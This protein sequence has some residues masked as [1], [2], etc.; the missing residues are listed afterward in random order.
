M[1]H[2]YKTVLTKIPTDL[3]GLVAAFL[4]FAFSPC[5]GQD[6]NNINSQSITHY[7]NGE[8][9][10][11]VKLADEALK[12][13]AKKYGEVSDQYINSLSNKAYAQSG[14]GNYNQATD[15]FRKVTILCFKQYSL[16][17]VVQVES[18][19]ELAKTF[20]TLSVYDSGALYINQARYVFNTIYEK[21]RNH[22]DTAIYV[23]ADA[24]FK[25]NSLDAGLHYRL[26]QF[27]EAYD[28]LTQQ[29]QFIKNIYPE[30]YINLADY[31]MTINNLSTYAMADGNMELAKRYALDYYLL[32][33]DSERKIDLI[34]ALQNLGS[35]HRNTENY[36]SAFYYWHKTLGEIYNSEYVNTPIHNITLSNIGELYLNLEVYDSAIYY[37]TNAIEI[38]N[39]KEA[40]DPNIYQTT[41]FNLAEAYHWAGNYAAAN[42]EYDIVIDNLLNEITHNFTYLSDDEK[43]SFYKNQQSI[44]ESYVFFA[45]EVSGAIKLQQ[46]ENP[47]I[48]PEIAGTLYD[49][50][51]TTKAIILN[52]SKRM[53]ENILSSND[54]TLIKIYSLWQKRK[55]V[56]A[57][58]L[59]EGKTPAEVLEQLRTRI[60]ENEKWL[61]TNS[62]NFKV[63]FAKERII[64]QDIQQQLKPDEAAVEI[65]RMANGLVYGTLILTP[66]TT[67]QPVISLVMSTKSKHL[68]KESFNAYKNAIQYQLTDEISYATYWK[69]II[70]SIMSH[71]PAKSMPKRIYISNDGIYNQL[72]INALYDT[73]SHQFVLDQ[74]EI[75]TLTNT[76]EILNKPENRDNKIHKKIVLFGEPSF[77]S[78]PHERAEYAALPGSGKEVQLINETLASADWDT[79]IYKETA[80]N[81]SNLKSIQNMNVLH[82]AS[83]GFFKPNANESSFSLI[84]TLLQSGIVLAGANDTT[85]VAEDGV[86]TAYE[87]VNL[88]LDSTELV[89]L[90]ACET[91]QGV[92]N[93]GE[94]VY[95]LQRAFRV[96]GV[97]NLIMSLWKVDDEATQKLMVSFYEHWIKT[98]DMRKAFTTAQKELRKEYPSP[99]YWGAFILTGM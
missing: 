20:I 68:E 61:I 89:V 65:I 18:L 21:N 48:N 34:H 16:P 84:E 43:I 4:V 74:T 91:A 11:A 96:A 19:T 99:Y 10:I 75:I 29:L 1:Y 71:M 45:L 76:K 37:L 64:W 51:L 33:K 24:Y 53:R 40:Y 54:T 59:V 82:L 49:L 58:E 44:L 97:N 2:K 28:I 7:R 27:G 77:S 98:N 93:H 73:T 14:L 83:H 88:P 25:L 52:S 35:T 57:Q 92:N 72:N 38:Q 70:D 8:Y 62:R 9:E 85:H 63:G 42:K 22:Y 87:V 78:Y 32:V 94:G 81:E 39:K 41:L 30:E 60:E 17:H 66:E 3:K 55:N 86:L 26:G 12:I 56:L 90:S 79:Q 80:A 69:P 36:D 23:L 15:N 67:H 5:F 46:S 31:Q 13:A 95:G 47:Y 6:W 50:Q